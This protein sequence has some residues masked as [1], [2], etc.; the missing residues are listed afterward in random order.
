MIHIT[1]M[2]PPPPDRSI[3]ASMGRRS[4]SL[5]L[6][7]LL[8]LLA[9]A[10]AFVIRGRPNVPAPR[11]CIRRIAASDAE[12]ARPGGG[13]GGPGHFDV[14]AAI[15]AADGDAAVRAVL[16]A[17]GV[18]PDGVDRAFTAWP[19]LGACHPREEVVR[20]LEHLNFLVGIGVY[21]GAQAEE[22]VATQP[23]FLA[24]RFGVVHE[25]ADLFVMEKPP[26]TRMDVP[27]RE[28]EGGERKWPTEYTCSDWLDSGVVDPP[29]EK[30]RFA[31]NL[32]SG[33]SGIL[34]LS[35]N[36]ETAARC[37]ELFAGRH[38]E[39]ECTYVRVVVVAVVVVA[40]LVLSMSMIDRFDCMIGKMIDNPRI[41][42]PHIQTWRWCSGTWRRTA[43]SSTRPSRRTRPA[44][45]ACAS[46]RAAAGRRRRHNWRS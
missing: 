38:V 2:F 6:L 25:D 32:D 46:P 1:P 35:K 39:K 37:N 22:L 12:A 19:R 36:R 23:R 33:T 16:L 44:A 21:T 3:D 27:A 29:L 26:D 7:S 18:S 20:R 10:F 8:A 45:F 5:A 42:M 31:H 14:G 43:S 34:V 4:A 17:A 28:G 9:P 15:A 41:R 30:K 11:T 13:G 40:G 24:M